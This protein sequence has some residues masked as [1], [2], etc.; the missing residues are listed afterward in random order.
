LT[1][2]DQVSVIVTPPTGVI[3]FSIPVVNIPANT[4]ITVNWQIPAALA[5]GSVRVL[6]QR[7]WDILPWS[8]S[9]T[10][11]THTQAFWEWNKYFF[12]GSGPWKIRF[13]VNGVI[14]KEETIRFLY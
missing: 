7:A 9:N 3:N 4:P 12:G 13:E 2:T 14:V 8:I 6:L 1:A 5:G 10:A 11:G